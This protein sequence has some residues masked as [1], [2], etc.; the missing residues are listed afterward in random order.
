M[1]LPNAQD[2]FIDPRKLTDYALSLKH[3]DGRHKATLFRDLVG[4]TDNEIESL[5]VALRDAAEN[6][7]VELGRLDKYGQRYLVDFNFTG[8]QGVALVRSVWIIL[9]QEAGPRLVTCY[10]L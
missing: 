2:A 1:R 9:S 5:L 7:E 6:G 8:P 3:E 4:V 10:I